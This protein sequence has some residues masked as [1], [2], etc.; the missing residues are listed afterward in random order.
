MIPMKEK[1]S[2]QGRTPY[3]GLRFYSALT[4]GI[5]AFL[6]LM[7]LLVLLTAAVRLSL[8]AGVI[9]SLTIYG[10]SMVALYTASTVYHS[11][12]TSV[13]GRN[14]LRKLD[15]VMIYFL[16]AGS[17]TPV[18]TIALGGTTAGR[19]ML[20]V[21]WVM[22]IAGSVFTM[23][24]IKMPR[25]LTAGIYIIMGWV[26]I[27][28]I[29]PLYHVLS[30]ACFALLLSG[31]LLYSVGGILYALKWPGKNNPRFGCHEIFH[32]FILLG[33][34]CHFLMIYAFL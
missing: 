27:F 28:A 13:H 8:S 32:V 23:T 11:W 1:L 15:H 24:W 31:G 20:A 34:I 22:A 17:Y 3:D 26:A 29:Y 7:G 4:H 2:E 12:R 9:T 19:V 25:L 16:I 33:S 10:V 5:G 14:V 30:T 21:I 6:A 18:C